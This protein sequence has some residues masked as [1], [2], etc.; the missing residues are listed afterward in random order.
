MSTEALNHPDGAPIGR[1]TVFQKGSALGRRL[2]ILHVIGS[3]AERYGGPSKVCV[4]ICQELARRGELVTIFTT[5][6]DGPDER[7]PFQCPEVS[8]RYFPVQRPRSFAF[9]TQLAIALRREIALFDVVHIH[10]LYR[11]PSTLAAIY[12]R[13]KHV[14][15]IIRP[16]GTLDPIVARRHRARKWLYDSLLERRNLNGAAAVHFTTNEEMEWVEA[17]GLR[18]TIKS[19]VVPNGVRLEDYSKCGSALG[20]RARHPEIGSKKII[21]FLGRLTAKKGLDI[22]ARAFGLL[23]RERTDLHL[24]I[25]GPDDEGYGV[26]V[27]KWL[28]RGHLLG[29]AS[30]TG[31]LLGENK[32]AAFA[33]ADIF[34]L[35]SYG[36]NFGVAV[37]EAMACK[38]PVVISDRVNI[39]PKV[40]DSNAGIV[41]PTDPDAIA[42]ALLSLLDNESRRKQMGECGHRLVEREFTWSKIG[43]QLIDEY[44]DIVFARSRSR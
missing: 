34:V 25:A 1:E 40:K 12:A 2:K 35:P 27:R 9:S 23:C 24:V 39:W 21:L 3:L 5:T 30:F 13:R 22:L 10:S 29:Q 32:L 7:E 26:K 42:E 16:H 14:P 28:A 4:E 20:F 43:R 37:V 44:Q 36:E 15:Y 19:I 41:T 6:L 38:L 17:K 18:P 8:I 33:A 11:M 31:M